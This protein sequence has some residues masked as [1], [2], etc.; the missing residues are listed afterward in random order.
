M[1]LRVPQREKE[2]AGAGHKAPSNSS[3]LALQGIFPFAVLVD[4]K[5][6][7]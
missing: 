4:E 3:A 5:A 1:R 7:A 2:D 6:R